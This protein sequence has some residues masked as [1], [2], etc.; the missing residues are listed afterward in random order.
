MKMPCSSA[1]VASWGPE[2]SSKRHIIVPAGNS[3]FS[4]GMDKIT[5]EIIDLDEKTFSTPNQMKFANIIR[6]YGHNAFVTVGV[7]VDDDGRNTIYTTLWSLN[8]T[9][10][11]LFQGVT[12]NQILLTGNVSG[13]ELI[14]IDGTYFITLLEKIVTEDKY[15][16]MRGGNG[17]VGF[18]G[19]NHTHNLE[20]APHGNKAK[21]LSATSLSD[22]SVPNGTSGGIFLTLSIISFMISLILNLIIRLFIQ[23]ITL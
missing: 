13:L 2:W 15:I 18:E 8:A 7:D 20:P 5:G 22:F 10:G 9:D 21:L 23:E 1:T 16:E 6:L 19:P 3:S 14:P 4:R 12:H 11:K 17:T